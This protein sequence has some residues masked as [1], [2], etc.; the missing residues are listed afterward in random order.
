M[1]EF[2][3][4]WLE[5][6]FSYEKIADRKYR[7]DIN[8]LH[9]Q[10]WKVYIKKLLTQIEKEH[11]FDFMIGDFLAVFPEDDYGINL[12][13]NWFNS[14]NIF[15]CYYDKKYYDKCY[16]VDDVF[17]TKK[18]VILVLVDLFIQ[19]SVNLTTNDIIEMSFVL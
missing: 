14:P 2:I 15:Y 8:I 1:P 5:K 17:M 18:E 10:I 16:G 19:S 12:H 13:F 7:K 11:D 6:Y 4:Y 9:V 3:D